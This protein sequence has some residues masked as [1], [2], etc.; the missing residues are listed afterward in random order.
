MTGQEFD[1]II[2]FVLMKASRLTSRQDFYY[3]YKNV[4]NAF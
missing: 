4:G 2:T 1:F 3:K